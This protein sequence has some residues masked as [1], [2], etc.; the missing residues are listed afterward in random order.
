MIFDTDVLIWCQR[1]NQAAAD[2][3]NHTDTLY[4]AFFSYMELLQNAQN[5]A[6]LKASKAFIQA[7]D[8]EVLPLTP[9]IGHRAAIYVEELTLSHSVTA[10]DALIAATAVEYDMPLCTG[11]LK[12]F[13]PIKG[14]QIH[15]FKPSG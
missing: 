11:N 10:S 7:F 6:Q 5:K 14:L 1:G 2:L 3:L 15:A 9:S 12:H 4:I 13:K 8:F